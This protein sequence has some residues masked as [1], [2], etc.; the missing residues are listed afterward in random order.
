MNAWYVDPAKLCGTGGGCTKNADGSYDF[1]LAVEFTP[2]RWL[3][4]GAVISIMALA[5]GAAYYLYDRRQGEQHK[6][7]RWRWHR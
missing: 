1:S 6:E 5:A 7:G 4:L 2:Q 3:Y